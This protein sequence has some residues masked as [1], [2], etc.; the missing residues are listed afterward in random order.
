[1]EGYSGFFYTWTCNMTTLSDGNHEHEHRSPYWLRMRTIQQCSMMNHV[2]WAMEM[3]LHHWAN[4]L[5]SFPPKCCIK[6]FLGMCPIYNWIVRA[7]RTCKTLVLFTHEWHCTCLCIIRCQ[8]PL[9]ELLIWFS[10]I[11]LVWICYIQFF[12]E[13]ELWNLLTII[14]FLFLY[15]TNIS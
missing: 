5:T 2:W 14:L 7:K 12:T 15:S 1:M 8:Y 9:I 3:L 13:N 6:C 4:K 11:K 10:R